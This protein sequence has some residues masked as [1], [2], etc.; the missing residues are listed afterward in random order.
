LVALAYAVLVS[1]SAAA[2]CHLLG[3]DRGIFP[4]RNDQFASFCLFE[5]SRCEVL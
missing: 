4:Q 5:L 3:A 2:Q 1:S